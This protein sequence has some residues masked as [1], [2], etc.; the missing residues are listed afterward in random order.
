[1]VDGFLSICNSLS[2]NEVY[3]DAS[4]LF[5][6][7]LLNHLRVVIRYVLLNTNEFGVLSSVVF[8]G[9]GRLVLKLYFQVFLVK[10]DNSF[11]EIVEGLVVA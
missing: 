4:E 9:D 8:A 2:S 5:V 1:M 10:Y 11:L 7:V 6:L 3:V